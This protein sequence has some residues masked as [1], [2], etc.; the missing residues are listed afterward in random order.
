MINYKFEAYSLASVTVLIAGLLK[1]HLYY[2]NFDVLIIPFLEIDEITTIFLDNL[3]YFLCFAF[4]N[5]TVIT[6]FY[7]LNFKDKIN[8]N[9]SSFFLKLKK[10][11]FFKWNKI[12]LFGITCIILFFA[13]LSRDKILLREY[14]MW[15]VLVFIAVYFNPFIIF[16]FKYLF[17]R[18]KILIAKISIIF[19]VSS[20]NLII[21]AASSGINEAYKVKYNNYYHQSEF[22][23][24]DLPTLI[25]NENKY[26]IGKTKEFVFFYLPKENSSEIIPI[27][28]IKRVKFYNRIDK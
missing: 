22:D 14:F 16:V 24:D 26:Y 8:N 18:K 9:K 11:G 4:L 5:I 15:T 13:Y 25:S 19:L 21:F 27:S 28:R 23:I 20:I 12:I 2:K 1:L 17:E 10:N 3:L 6:F 7:N